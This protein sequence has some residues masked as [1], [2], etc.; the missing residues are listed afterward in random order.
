MTYYKYAERSAESYIN[1]AEVGKNMSDMLLEEKRVREEKIAAIDENTRE[2]QRILQNAPTGEHDG[3]NEWVL[4]FSV[5]AQKALLMQDRL[6]KSGELSLR[7]YTIQRQNIID[8]AQETFGVMKNWNEDY[9][10]KLKEMQEG[11]TA[12]Q[13][14]W[15]MMDIESFGNFNSHGLYINPTNFKISIGKRQLRNPDAPY[16]PV[17]NPYVAGVSSNPNDL[18]SV[19]ALNNRLNQTIERVDLG[20]NLASSVENFAE[21]YKEVKMIGDVKTEDNLR[22]IDEWETIKR[23]VV[24]EQLVNPLAVGSILSDTIG[25]NPDTL[26]ENGRNGTPWGFTKDPDEAT[27]DPSLILLIPDPNQPTSG[28][29]VPDFS[30]PNGQRQ[31]E[32]AY[33]AV[34]AKFE[35]QISKEEQPKSEF[36]PQREPQPSGAQIGA[37]EKK[38]KTLGYM[39]NLNRLMAGG[40][41]DF[42]AASTDIVGSFENVEKG[43]FRPVDFARENGVITITLDDGK[44][45]QKI[46]KIDMTE[47]GITDENIGQKLWQFVVPGADETSF[48]EGLVAWDETEGGGFIPKMIEDPANPGTMIP[49]PDYKGLEA[50]SYQQAFVPVEVKGVNNTPIMV[51]GEV[52]TVG[53]TFNNIKSW[54]DEQEVVDVSKR[55]LDQMLKNIDVPIQ[56]SWHDESGAKNTLV[57]NVGGK[58]YRATKQMKDKNAI[59]AFIENIVREQV[60]MWNDSEGGR[61]T[62]NSNAAP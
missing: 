57:V 14:D 17:E 2:T 52:S 24:E 25:V 55:A 53:A 37:D 43:I 35:S 23:D 4:G 33:D 12:G 3:Y 18:S 61:K 7:D 8:G 10:A 47:E 42:E 39:T 22:L 31:R 32:I 16:D 30:T 28:M 49:N 1:W 27:N 36:A 6:L 29:L 51:D 20:K 34:A 48:D 62:N 21:V 40:S 38:R 59:I 19:Q 5:D 45:N 46:E 54:K 44:G 26:D 13:S 60:G 15:Q 9:E 56:V 50:G 58:E 41:Q 11:K